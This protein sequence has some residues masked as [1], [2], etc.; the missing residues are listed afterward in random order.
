MIAVIFE[1]EP[2]PQRTEDYF[3]I[4]LE[5]GSLLEE[6]D[7]FISIERFESVSSPGKYLSL[8]FWRDETAITQWRNLKTHRSAQLKGRAS[9]FQHYRLRV[10]TIIRDYSLCD[11]ENVPKDSQGFHSI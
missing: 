10:A 6:I 2:K 8:S 4:A 7:G 11:R 3:A 1:L 9:I 5:L